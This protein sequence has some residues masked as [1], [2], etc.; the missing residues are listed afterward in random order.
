MR[1]LPDSSACTY[2]LSDSKSISSA[3]RIEA[4]SSLKRSHVNGILWLSHFGIGSGEEIHSWVCSIWAIGLLQI[5]Q[6]A[7]AVAALAVD[8]GLMI[9]L[10]LVS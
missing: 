2:L 7:H 10:D 3:E 4:F 1:N 5:H 8:S 9:L 6:A